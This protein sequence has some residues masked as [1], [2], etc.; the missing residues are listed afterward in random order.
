[1]QR[2]MEG[3]KDNERMMDVIGVCKMFDTHIFYLHMFVSIYACYQVP[4]SLYNGPFLSITFLGMKSK[5]RA[6]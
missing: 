2:S 6:I 3:Q 5:E 4:P 1:M